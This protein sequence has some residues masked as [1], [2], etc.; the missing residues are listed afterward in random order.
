MPRYGCSA[1][2]LD[3]GG[4]LEEELVADR[5]QPLAEVD[6]LRVHEEAL[7]EPVELLQ[8]LAP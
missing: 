3:D 6:V 7:V 8:R 2:V 5:A 1:L 4:R